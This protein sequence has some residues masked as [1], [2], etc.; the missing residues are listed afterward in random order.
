MIDPVSPALQQASLASATRSGEAAASAAEQPAESFGAF[1]GDT[2]MQF[3]S[4]LAAAEQ[5]AIAGMK[6]EAPVADVVASVMEAE[7]SL[8]LA[9]GIRDKVVSAWMEVSR[10]Q[11]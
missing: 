7:R 5:A 11:I 9:I 6:G 1:L 4:N 10:M 3:R 8:R 2:A